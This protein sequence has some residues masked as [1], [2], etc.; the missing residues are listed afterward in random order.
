MLD[1]EP[2]HRVIGALRE[3]LVAAEDPQRVL[4]RL[5]APD[6][7][8]VTLTITEKGYCLAPDGH[9]DFNHVDVRQ[10]L[11]RAEAPVSAIGYLVE[12]LRQRRAA[13]LRPY[14]VISCDNLADNGSKLGRAVI[15]YAARVDR[16]LARW[17]EDEAA[18]PRTMVD[19][20]VPASDDALRNRI[21]DA[22][23]V[24]DAWPVQREAWLQWV[25]A[26]DTRGMGPDW[27]SVGVTVTD[28]VGGYEST[29]LRLLNGAHSSLAYL[30]LIRGHGSVG[31]AMADA[32]LAEL[33]RRLMIDDIKPT[34]RAPSELNVDAYIDAVLKRFRNPAIRHELAQI[35]WDGSQKLPV[36]LFGTIADALAT[37]RPTQRLCLPVAAWLRFLRRAA[38]DQR[39]VVDPLAEPLLAIAAACDN[40]AAHD[41]DL[42]LNFDQVFPA[43]LATD[44]RFRTALIQAYASLT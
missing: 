30:G 13:G 4:A 10:D 16:D 11:S 40:D 15:A 33:I 38:R 3:R 24:D 8:V 41:I 22:L 23:G 19:S 25:I 28:D 1:R 5:A 17:I 26:D 37:G 21:R 9:L 7:Q 35:A 12:G 32:E 39:P 36:R 2:R 14:T 29:K 18:F 31:E 20:I 43:S 34:V 27:T 6:T 44:A 42:L